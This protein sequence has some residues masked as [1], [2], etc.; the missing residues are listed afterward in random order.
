M[1][2]NGDRATRCSVAVVIRRGADGFY[3]AVR[4]PFQDEQLPGLWGLPAGTL[5]RGELPEQAVRRI[6]LEKLGVRIEPSRFLGIKSANRGSHELILM[7]IEATLE[8]GN[9]DVHSAVTTRTRYID[10]QWTDRLELLQEAADRGSLCCQ[11][12]LAAE[13]S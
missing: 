8:E 2:S 12:F 13:G 3:L 4:R 10:Q 7:D 9:P 11:I 5:E 1:V 6:G